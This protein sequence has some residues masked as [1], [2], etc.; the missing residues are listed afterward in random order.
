MDAD[1]TRRRLLGQR[2]VGQLNMIW[3]YFARVEG[4]RWTTLARELVDERN[5]S[6][7][8]RETLL[9]RGNRR[10]G[11]SRVSKNA[12]QG[13]KTL[14]SDIVPPE[15]RLELPA[16]KI[17]RLWH[18]SPSDASQESDAIAREFLA[19]GSHSG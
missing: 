19:I 7:R 18:F 15:T 17:S 10:V 9:R 1:R 13:A 12:Q 2:L 14:S 8:A 6:E 16:R 11:A 3:R 4:R 5:A